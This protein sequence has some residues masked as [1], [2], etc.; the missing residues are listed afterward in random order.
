MAMYADFRLD[1]S[2]GLILHATYYNIKPKKPHV[3]LSILGVSVYILL[4]C[5]YAYTCAHIHTAFQIF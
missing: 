5:M 1:L 2:L 4:K 3:A